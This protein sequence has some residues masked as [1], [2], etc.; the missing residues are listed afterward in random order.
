VSTGSDRAAQA[1]TALA[2][3]GH[4]SATRAGDRFRRVRANLLLIIQAGVAAGLAWWVAHDLVGHTAP[5]FSPISAVIVIAVAVGQ[6]M[7]RAVELVFG[8]ALG[9]GVGDTLIYFIGTGLWQIALVVALAIATVIFIGGS[10]TVIG[11][12]SSSAVLV[13]TLAPPATGIYYSRFV[14]ALIGGAVGIVVLALLLPLNPLTT[15]R[16]AANPALELLAAELTN[17]ADALAL[18][19]AD[20]GRAALERMRASEGKLTS[21]QNALH[22]ANETASLAPVRWRARAPLAQ[23]VD[24]AVHLDRA[25][26]NVRVLGRR[27]VSAI[28]VGETV[29]DG[30]V[31]ALRMLADT[32]VTLRAELAAGLE[33][34][35]TRERALSSVAVA[36]D[37]YREGVGFSTG[38]VVAQVRS[39]ATDLLRATGLDDATSARAVRRAVGRLST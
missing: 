39:I 18:G 8:V 3:I 5:F 29:P 25:I 15:V 16:K 38:V 33:P 24:A 34:R 11:Q 1:A 4:R 23:Y 6:R 26:R 28:E 32:V 12:A 31:R 37:A 7:R 20:L 10:P 21:L 35:R 36:A 19:D 14:D 30:V 9:I 17:S 22:T 27:T 2:E 13:A